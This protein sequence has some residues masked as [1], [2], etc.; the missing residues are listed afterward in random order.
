MLK[1]HSSP[2]QTKRAEYEYISRGLSQSAIHA[3]PFQCILATV[4]L[5]AEY[6]LKSSVKREYI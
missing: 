6:G 4:P 1:L 3:D 5:R 2:E